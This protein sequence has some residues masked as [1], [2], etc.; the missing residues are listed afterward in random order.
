MEGANEA[1]RRAVNGI[2]DATGSA[3]QRC[4]VWPLRE[5]SV[6]EAARRADRVLW[7]VGRQPVRPPVII[8]PDGKL[9]PA[10]A[11]ARGLAGLFGLFGR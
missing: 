9:E 5:P 7:T 3:A 10:G 4:Q 8:G 6:F 1:A 2:L 11:I